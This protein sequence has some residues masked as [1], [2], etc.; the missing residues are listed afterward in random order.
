M[1]STVSTGTLHSPISSPVPNKMA[2][3]SNGYSLVV[4]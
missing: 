1:F 2:L 4:I 3:P